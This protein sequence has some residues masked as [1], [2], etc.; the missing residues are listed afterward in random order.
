MTTDLSWMLEDIVTNVPKARHAVLL[1]ADGVPL[2]ASEGL[3]SKDVRTI[4]AAMAGMQSLSRATSHFIEPVKDPRWHQT[5]IEFSHGWI[6]LIGAGEGAYLAAAAEPDVDIQQISF[7]M[8]RLVARLGN[9]LTSPP[10]VDAEESSA[11]GGA[12]ARGAAG[13]R[14]G[15]VLADLDQVIAEVHGA[16]HAVLLGINGL[17]RGASS[18]ISRNLVDTISAAMTGIH[19]YS[20]VTSQFNGVHEDAGWRQTVIEFQHGWIFLIAGSKGSLLAAAAEHDTDIEEFTTRLHEVVPRLSE[21]RISR[22][23]APSDA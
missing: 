7:R 2:G 15:L 12:S 20:R 6:F 3:V 16:R 8:H 19:A 4:S 17:P 23:G 22:E 18:G 14:G 1:S 10:R 21:E 5:I 9:N 11:D 13:D